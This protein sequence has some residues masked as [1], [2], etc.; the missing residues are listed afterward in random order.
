[1]LS[2]KAPRPSPST[3]PTD[4][5]LILKNKN[6]N[7]DQIFFLAKKLSNL[8]ILPDLGCL[9]LA[10]FFS[11]VSSF[12][13]W[14]TLRFFEG[15]SYYCWPFPLL[16]VPDAIFYA[17]AASEPPLI[18]AFISSSFPGSSTTLKA[19]LPKSASYWSFLGVA[20]LNTFVLVT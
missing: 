20:F 11:D 18:L 13:I 14:E 1:M 3:P 4:D 9:P 15:V 10:G 5:R 19:P 16:L 6:L 2:L 8:S 17:S 12:V 7:L